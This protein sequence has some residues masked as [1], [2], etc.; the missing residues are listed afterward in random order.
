[1]SRNG[2]VICSRPQ[3]PICGAPCNVAAATRKGRAAYLQG[4]GGAEE[5][6]RRAV[7][8]ELDQRNADVMPRY[9]I[10][11]TSQNALLVGCERFVDAA[12]AA[13]LVAARAFDLCAF[14]PT[15]SSPRPAP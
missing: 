15:C 3:V 4:D 10:T 5:I 1:M 9:G 12:D 13:Q 2:E 14:W 7:V 8:P 11:T 6:L